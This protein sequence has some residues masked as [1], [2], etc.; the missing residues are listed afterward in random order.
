[1]PTPPRSR[2]TSLTRQDTR[3]QRH[4]STGGRPTT[5]VTDHWMHACDLAERQ[6]KDHQQYEDTS[7][8]GSSTLDFKI[9]SNENSSAWSQISHHDAT[10][11]QPEDKTVSSM[12]SL[13]EV[14]ADQSSSI[15]SET[16]SSTKREQEI[17][18]WPRKFTN[19]LAGNRILRH[20]F[21]QVDTGTL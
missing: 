12:D 3:E 13:V 21:Y 14:K 1:M 9:I 15:T 10:L 19:Q 5:G 11:S 16:S 6:Q 17:Q 8:K 4:D 7:E 18:K 20:P 2:D